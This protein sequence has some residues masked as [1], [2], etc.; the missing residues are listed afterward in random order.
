MDWLS[1]YFVALY[2]V[3]LFP[4]VFYKDLSFGLCLFLFWIT[5]AVKVR[6]GALFIYI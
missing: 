1:L 3:F 6:I 2:E 5:D 4:S